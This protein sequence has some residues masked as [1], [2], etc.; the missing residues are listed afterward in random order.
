MDWIL[1]PDSLPAIVE[2]KYDWEKKTDGRRNDIGP[3]QL[4]DCS[5]TGLPTGF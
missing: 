2:G 1:K 4:F 5:T 3:G